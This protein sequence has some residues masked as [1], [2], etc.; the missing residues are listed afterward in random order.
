MNIGIDIRKIRDYGIGTHIRNVIL[1]AAGR[2]PANRYFLFC[3]PADFQQPAKN[4]VWV[5]D[6]SPKYSLAE[7]FSLAKKAAQQKLDLFHSPHFTLPFRLK[8]KA[9]VT[10]HDLIHLKFQHFFPHWKVKAAKFVIQKSIRKAEVILAVS[11]TTKNDI[12]QFFPQAE[13]KVQVLYNR[14]SEEWKASGDGYDVASLGLSKDYLLYVGNFK[15][16]KGLDTLV[17]AYRKLKEPPPL[18]LVGKSSGIDQDLSDAIF[19]DP[20]IRVFGFADGKLLRSLYSHALLFVFPSLYE[21]FGYPPLEAMSCGAPVLSSD[22][23]ALKEVLQNAA[24]YFERGNAEELAHKLENLMG[25]HT[26]RSTL[27]EAGKVR[28]GH[29][30]N[31]ESPDKL[32]EIYRKVAS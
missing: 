19:S 29:F 32:L 28:A 7:H 15:K 8:E 27:K 18:V 26:K 10:I 3:D 30:M 11:Q 22:A 4:F 16:H 20:R 1:Y 24:E 5:S 9:I 14:L 21:G 31:D 12:L 23:P 6:D 25:D 17:Q 13:G 2:D